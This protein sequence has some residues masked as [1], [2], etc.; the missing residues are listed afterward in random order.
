MHCP[1]CCEDLLFELKFVPHDALRVS[2]VHFAQTLQLLV[3]LL[4]LLY[5]LVLFFYGQLQPVDVAPEFIED[6]HHFLAIAR[7]NALRQQ[8]KFFFVVKGVRY[9]AYTFLPLH[10]AQNF[11]SSRLGSKNGST[12]R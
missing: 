2:I 8:R 11:C 3:I 4:V 6:A 7:G 10:S 9:L 12:R 1:L 5:L